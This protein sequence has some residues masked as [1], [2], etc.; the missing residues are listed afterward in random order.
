M[1]D[2]CDGQQLF[3]ELFDE[4]DKGFGGLGGFGRW[5]RVMAALASASAF[6]S[7]ALAVMGFSMVSFFWM[8][9]LARLSSDLAIMAACLASVVA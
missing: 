8:A 5:S 4:V 6:T 3:I 1:A 2:Q 7:F 9:A